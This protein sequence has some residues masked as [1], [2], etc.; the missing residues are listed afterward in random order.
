MPSISSV[1]AMLGIVPRL[2]AAV[3]STSLVSSNPRL[4]GLLEHP[5]GPVTSAFVGGGAVAVHGGQRSRRS[6]PARASG[7]RVLHSEVFFPCPPSPPA[8]HF[9]A[10]TAKWAI[11]AA[12][13][14][15]YNRPVE[16]MSAPQQGGAFLN[17]SV[18]ACA[19]A[20]CLVF[21]CG[22]S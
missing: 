11:S 16:K 20:P 4:K 21:G 14:A 1:I 3:V 17:G 19:P 9:W 7:L 15:D 22:W 18:G 8:V 6:R 5:A 10:P 13:I 12:N 2:Q